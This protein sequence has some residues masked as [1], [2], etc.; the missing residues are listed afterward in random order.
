[1]RSRTTA[2]EGREVSAVRA[3][4]A[5]VRGLERAEDAPSGTGALSA[6]FKERLALRSLAY[7]VP[8]HANGLLYT[9]G[10]ITAFGFGVLIV[11]GV[12]LAQ[13]YDPT[14]E[15]ARASVQYIV[16]SA[17]F[18]EF[19]RGIHYWTAV[20]VTITVALHLLRVFASAAYKAPREVNWLVGVALL[21]VTMGFVFT[22]TAIKW[23][24]EGAEALLHN[25]AA[26]K[27]LGALG[28]W[29]SS[30][31]SLAVPLLTR[32]FFAHVAILPALLTALVAA[33]FFLIKAH[34]MAPMG[35]ADGYELARERYRTPS[36]VYG[37]DMRPF[38]SH[39][40]KI[41]GWGLFVTSVAMALA[42]AFPPALGPVAVAGIEIT[43]PP[44]MFW[45]LYAAED[46]LGISGLLIVPAAF[47]LLLAIVPF[48][49]R[50]RM[51]A[52]RQRKAVVL[53]GILVVLLLVGL[54]AYTGLTPPVA[55]TQMG[56]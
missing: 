40:R 33:H 25:Q 28:G 34:G 15:A 6:W 11:T 56:M 14:P 42:L 22:G 29:F 47:F 4:N 54:T 55:H 27:L 48:V 45:W 43:K 49:D 1:M 10:G 21:A 23:D 8:A 53:A 16:T 17:P 31:F 39:I 18:G 38:D 51:R 12:Y 37:E 19:I 52:I 26:A 3:R 5:G 13:F 50:G 7:P 30:D 35:R 36:A 44:V 2:Q 9:L 20:V 41:A 46:A 24:Q 32:V